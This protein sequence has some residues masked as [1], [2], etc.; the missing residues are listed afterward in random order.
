MNVEC[1]H[2]VLSVIIGESNR[3]GVKTCNI[4]ATKHRAQFS[5]L[6]AANFFYFYHYY[7]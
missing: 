4:S 5:I 7:F 3:L 1:H 2:G 6:N